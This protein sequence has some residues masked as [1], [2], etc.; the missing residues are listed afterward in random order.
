M[1]LVTL[2]LPFCFFDL[3]G[4]LSYACPCSSFLAHDRP[5]FLI[6]YLH[7]YFYFN[8]VLITKY[9]KYYSANWYCLLPHTKKKKKRFSRCL[10]LFGYLLILHFI[11]FSLHFILLCIKLIRDF[12]LG[13]VWVCDFR[14]CGLKIA[15]LNKIIFWP[16]KIVV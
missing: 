7:K 8:S 10:S 9:I 1:A 12:N 15:I 5:F 11:W 2:N 4:A 16:L 6:L 14:K 3:F 13:F